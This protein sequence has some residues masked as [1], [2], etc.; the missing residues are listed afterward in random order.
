M[1]RKRRVMF[2][3]SVWKKGDGA[4]KKHREKF[5]GFRAQIIQHELDHLDGIII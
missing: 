1:E 4:W 3:Q 5:S 2:W